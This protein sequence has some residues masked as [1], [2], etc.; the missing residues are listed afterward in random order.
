MIVTK[1]ANG[2]LAI[3]VWNL[4][5]P[6]QKGTN[7]TVKLVFSHLDAAAEVRIQK[8][9]E[10]HGNALQ[11]YAAMGTPLDPTPDQVEQLNRA[12]ALA[13]PEKTRLKGGSLELNLTHNA[14]ALITVQPKM[15]E[16]PICNSLAFS[17]WRQLL[18]SR[19]EK[20]LA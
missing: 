20:G 7:R 8:L 17:N 9:D 11:Q 6:G 15:T 14:L 10:D 5:D 4:V 16:A 19:F 1:T 2:G 13:P 3:A 18:H 12:T